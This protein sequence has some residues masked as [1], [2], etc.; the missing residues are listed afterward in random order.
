M[1]GCD[2]MLRPLSR[3]AR[4]PNTGEELGPF[5]LLAEVGRGACGK[6]YLA[7]EPALGNRLVVLKVITDDQEEHLSL[8]RLRHTHIIPLVFGTELARTRA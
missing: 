8:A 1:L 6:T 2:R 4:F 5:R 3:V 7:A